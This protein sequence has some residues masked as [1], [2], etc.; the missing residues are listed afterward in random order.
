MRTLGPS[1]AALAQSSWSLLLMAL[2]TG[3]FLWRIASGTPGDEDGA[4]EGEDM[5][6][7]MAFFLW[8]GWAA[9]PWSLKTVNSSLFYFY[10]FQY[11]FVISLW[12]NL[13]LFYRSQYL[14]VISLWWNLTL[15]YRYQCVDVVI[16]LWWNSSLVYR[17]QHVVVLF[18]CDDLFETDG[19]T[20]QKGDFCMV[21]FLSHVLC[22]FN[23][24]SL[25]L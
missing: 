3:P 16:W 8:G 22:P 6:D 9:W 5:A 4:Q 2:V 21:F 17:F 15:F 10:C 7:V 24:C 12:C 19:K 25:R 11:L 18:C 1:S 13:T 23:K 14:F 20:K